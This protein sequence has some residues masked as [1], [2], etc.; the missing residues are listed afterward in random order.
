MYEPVPTLQISMTEGD[1]QKV[2]N[3]SSGM[4]ASCAIRR[5]YS[6][7]LTR[8]VD[9][10][11]TSLANI[12]AYYSRSKAKEC[13]ILYQRMCCVMSISL[14]DDYHSLMYQYLDAINRMNVRFVSAIWRELRSPRVGLTDTLIAAIQCVRS[15]CAKHEY[16]FDIEKEVKTLKAAVDELDNLL[17]R[18]YHDLDQMET[19]AIAG[20]E[21]WINENPPVNLTHWKTNP[22]ERYCHSAC[23]GDA[24]NQDEWD[25]FVE[26]QT[27]N[28]INA[29]LAFESDRWLAS[30]DKDCMTWPTG[31]DILHAMIKKHNK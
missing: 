30:K 18:P 2:G 21:E 22:C 7:V 8:P 27:Y 15:R 11:K 25:E 6:N 3:D 20:V 16:R 19:E 17:V 14:R 31:D 28:K 12:V 1:Q 23:R 10:F 13:R 29:A 4:F 24:L 26:K 9:K 5:W